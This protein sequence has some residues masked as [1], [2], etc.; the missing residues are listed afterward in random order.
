MLFA[1][2]DPTTRK[3]NLPKIIKTNDSPAIVS[4]LMSSLPISSGSIN[5]S[6]VD[7]VDEMN[8]EKVETTGSK[9]NLTNESIRTA[10]IQSKVIS[11]PSSSY[12]NDKVSVKKMTN[13]GKDD[14]V[15]GKGQEVFLTDTV[16][17][18]SKLPT[19]LVAAFRYPRRCL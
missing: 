3:I 13:E 18:I 17:F 4:D 12:L 11:Y 1:T 5:Y 10:A 6:K 9:L 2:L 15:L 7:I 19:D 16:G 8:D 14:V